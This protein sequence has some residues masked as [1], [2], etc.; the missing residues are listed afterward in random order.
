MRAGNSCKKSLSLREFSVRVLWVFLMI[1]CLASSVE[2]VDFWDITVL[3]SVGYGGGCSSVAILP[4]GQPAISYRKKTSNSLMYAWYDGSAWQTTTVGWIGSWGGWN[5]L[6][7]LP[8]GYPAISYQVTP[9]PHVRRL[10]YAWYDGSVWQTTIVD[11]GG[12]V[13][14][15]NSLAIL[16]SGQPAISYLDETNYDLKYA[17]LVGSDPCDPN[18]WQRI[19]VDSGGTVGAFN[20]LAILPS[21]QPAISY[22]DETNYDLKYA[23]LVGSDPC[24]PNDWQRI[25]VD[26]NDGR[27]TSLAILPSGYP[28]ISYYDAYQDVLKYAWY[29]GSTWQTTIVD[30]VGNI[31]GDNSLAILPSGHPAVSYR[32]RGNNAS[33]LKYAWY[34]GSVWQTTIVDIGGD[35]GKY[36]SLA[37]VPS[38]QSV[39][40]YYDD[41]YDYSGSEGNGDL[42]F[43]TPL[44]SPT[45]P[46]AVSVSYTA[47]A[48]TDLHG[49]TVV[50][51]GPAYNG[52]WVGN[53]APGPVESS[54]SVETTDGGHVRAFVEVFGEDGEDCM[55]PPDCFF[56][57][58][59]SCEDANGTVTGTLVLGTSGT[60]PASSE[61]E[62][63]LEVLVGGDPGDAEDYHLQLWRGESLLSQID[64]CAPDSIVVP[65][66]AGETLTF[67]LFASEEDWGGGDYHGYKRGFEFRL[68]LYGPANFDGKGSVDFRDY[69]IFVLHWL[70]TG[71]VDPTWCGKADLNKTGEVN[72]PDLKIFTGH[73]LE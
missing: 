3:D 43:A 28:A 10:E 38:G 20:S 7:I 14:A 48:H 65:V 30:S 68:I 12:S 8:S 21:G 33:D 42:K 72:W 13:G 37:I 34:N 57:S 52:G 31:S 50:I 62:L 29:D 45:A 9:S 73:W 56:T 17:E 18:D 47:K 6:A 55:D 2:A 40:S 11:S 66:L 67:E 19:V 26:S 22:L 61:L 32:Y 25:V 4:S 41:N 35:V 51:D 24:D 53:W 1:A 59:V 49:T 64:P 54:V 23:E 36:N 44:A 69:A 5:S 15:F 71:C 16:P 63:A 39:I 58:F 27:Y 46:V 70:D 60:Y